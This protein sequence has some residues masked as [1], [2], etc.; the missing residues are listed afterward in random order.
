MKPECLAVQFLEALQGHTH[1]QALTDNRDQENEQVVAGLFS[2]SVD[3]LRSQFPN[4]AIQRL[5]R[6]NWE[7]YH[8]GVVSVR[9]DRMVSAP[10]FVLSGV[11]GAPQALTILPLQWV[12]MFG[13]DPIKQM[14]LVVFIAS[15][16]V[17][18]FHERVFTEAE[19]V[20]ERARAHEA[21]YLLTIQHLAPAWEPDRYQRSI[22]GDYPEG[23]ASARAQPLLYSLKPFI[24]AA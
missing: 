23:L 7:V 14:G 5:L 20:V 17:D 11:K 12:R 18:Y 19:K 3:F 16:S 21:E 24:F 10:S 4:P 1:I 2:A 22:L 8:Y 6:F 9:V 13:R 15:Q